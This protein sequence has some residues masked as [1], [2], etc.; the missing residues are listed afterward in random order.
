MTK[1]IKFIFIGFISISSFSQIELDKSF[2][3]SEVDGWLLPYTTSEE[4]YYYKAGAGLKTVQIFNS[5]YSLKAEFTPT[6]P[7]GVETF[8][9]SLY[10]EN[11]GISKNIFNTDELIEIVI[12]YS[13]GEFL[14]EQKVRIYN[15]N[16]EILEDF[17]DNE[18]FIEDVYDFIVFN[19]KTTSTNK[20]MMYNVTTDSTEIYTLTSSLATEEINNI[21][22]LKSF[23]NPAQSYLNIENL[24]TNKSEVKVYDVNGR[25][26][27][28]KLIKTR[29]KN[30]YKIDLKGLNTGVYFYTIGETKRKFIKK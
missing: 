18:Y 22:L 20:L 29:Q 24:N 28:K 16:G 19:D 12:S 9:I 21:S 27:S 14:N 26:F 30:T 17:G 23:P 7:S 6:L 2:A 3:Y 5:D 1:I 15:E 13:E 11:L 25:E 8:S 10:K 4:T